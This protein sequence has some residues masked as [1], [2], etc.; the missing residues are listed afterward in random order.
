MYEQKAGP[1]GFMIIQKSMKKC[2]IYLVLKNLN[3]LDIDKRRFLKRI[4]HELNNSRF[5]KTANIQDFY[6]RLLL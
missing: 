4:V 1:I 6:S 5:L 2:R 3:K